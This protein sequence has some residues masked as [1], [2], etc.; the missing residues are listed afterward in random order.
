MNSPAFETR[1][2]AGSGGLFLTADVGGDPRAQAVL[3]MHGGGQTRHSWRGAT[4]RLVA[5]GYHVVSLDTRGHGDSDWSA[6]GEY[7]LDVLAADLLAV[8]AT[9]R[10][11][12]V[13]VGASLGGSTGLYAVGNSTTPIARA[14]VMVDVIP[15]VDPVGA[16]KIVSFMRSH[17]SGFAN[18][19]EAIDAV[20][21]YNPHRPRP[22]DPAGLMKNL[23]RRA[24]GRLYWHWDPQIVKTSSRLEPPDLVEPLLAAASRVRIPTLLVRGLLSDV[25]TDSGIEELRGVLP[26]LEVYGVPNA[27]HMVAGDRNDVFSTAIGSFL[28]RHAAVSRHLLTGTVQSR[29]M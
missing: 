9:L 29:H 25:V 7:G 19:E 1:R 8:I 2:Y 21:A 15:R 23:R 4:Q 24:D 5:E 11:R 22:K 27:G 10:T 3:L 13:L 20:A 16:E 26:S 28:S 18:V 17:S 6:A 14:L 12:P